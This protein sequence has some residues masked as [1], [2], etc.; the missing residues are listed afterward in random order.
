MLDN[1]EKKTSEKTDPL[2][3]IA[4]LD[5]SY[6]APLECQD[7]VTKEIRLFCQYFLNVEKDTNKSTN[8]NVDIPVDL[9]NLPSFTITGWKKQPDGFH[10]GTYVIMFMLCLM[11]H[12]NPSIFTKTLYRKD[13]HFQHTT[14]KMTCFKFDPT[15]DMNHMRTEL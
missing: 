11:R 8:K 4:V 13:I 3:F 6:T 5:S 15:K 2:P 1:N 12:V 10:C 7:D 14:S 9:V